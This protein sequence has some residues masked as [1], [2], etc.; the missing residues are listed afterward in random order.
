MEFKAD[1]Y[2]HLTPSTIFQISTQ[3]PHFVIEHTRPGWRIIEWKGSQI[4]TYVD[5]LS[6]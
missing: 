5:Y 1:K 6:A 2:I 3:T 4:H